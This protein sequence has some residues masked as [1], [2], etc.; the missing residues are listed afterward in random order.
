M[1]NVYAIVEIQNG[2][3]AII[4]FVEKL[5]VVN[6]YCQSIEGNIKKN[7]LLNIE[8]LILVYITYIKQQKLD[9]G[10]LKQQTINTIEEDE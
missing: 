9:V 4:L 2:Y 10:L 8:C 3:L 6:V 5:K 1:K 7:T